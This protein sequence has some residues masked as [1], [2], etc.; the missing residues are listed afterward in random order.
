[1]LICGTT[2]SGKTTGAKILVSRYA[3]ENISS[4]VL[5]PLNDPEWESPHRFLT[6]AP[7]Y[8]QA[9]ASRNCAL[10]IDEAALSLDR[11]DDR[12]NWFAT[13]SRHWGHRSHFIAQRAI[14][15]NPTIRGQCGCYMIFRLDWKDAEEL[16]RNFTRRELV[17]ASEL[18]AG[19]C[20]IGT[21]FEPPTRCRIDFAR[22]VLVPLGTWNAAGSFQTFQVGSKRGAA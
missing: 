1:M 13:V 21:R 19:E 5:D 3:R 12:L 20:I 11:F 15:V 6:V 14:G 22:R 17:V 4:L 18:P 2:E 16:A 10:I 9:K 8:A 7:F